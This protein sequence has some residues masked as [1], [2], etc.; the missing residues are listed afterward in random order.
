MG[1]TSS[2]SSTSPSVPRRRRKTARLRFRNLGERYLVR[3]FP[4][5]V[6]ADADGVPYAIGTGYAQGIGVMPSLV[7]IKLARKQP[8]AT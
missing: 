8:D 3:T 2:W 1:I 7:M 5:I 4:T 6:L